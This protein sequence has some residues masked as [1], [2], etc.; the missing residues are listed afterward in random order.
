MT[1]KPFAPTEEQRAVIDHEGSAFV[2]ACPGAGKTRILIE[3]ARELFGALRQGQGIAF[4]SFTHA[5]V[6]ELETRLSQERLL[7]A[8]IFP[9]F[10]GTFDSFVW[11]FLVAPFGLPGATVRPRLIADTAGLPVEPY[12]NAQTLPLSCFCP[13]TGA[14]FP[15]EAKSKG[16]DVSKK[17]DYQVQAYETTASRIR[18]R[19]LARGHLGFDEARSVALQRISDTQIARRIAL[20]LKGRFCEVIVDEAQDCNPDDLRI[21]AWLRDSGLP[22]KVVCDPNQAIYEFRG[23]VTDHLSTFAETFPAAQ[24]KKVTGNFRSSPNICKAVAGFRPIPV[25]GD[26]DEALGS[27]RGHSASVEILSY[28]GISV[29]PSIGETFSTILRGAGILPSSAPIVASTKASGAAA[30]GQP[31]ATGSQDRTLRLAEV[32]SEF[33]FAAGYSDMK[34]AMDSAHE[35]F[36]LLEGK[37]GGLSYH[38]Y[39]AD[40]DIDP[41]SWRSQVVKLLRTLR[42]S[43]GVHGDAR[44]WHG[45]V[46]QVLER[47][48]SIDDGQTISQKLRWNTNLEGLLA[49][50]PTD[51]PLPRTIHSV[52]GMQFPAVCVV[53]TSRTL[54]RILDFLLT[55]EPADQAENARKLYVAASRAEKLLVLAVPRSQALRLKTHLEAQGASV[56]VREI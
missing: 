20:A 46:K 17:Q 32:V 41:A 2:D 8:P 52:K 7:P 3:R 45:A 21:I 27:L 6:F 42:F 54:G 11:H 53:M 50:A 37:L 19:L 29:P 55:G 36:L 22:T 25:R 31:K 5:A 26:P 39:I 13:D 44:G 9:N 47:E 14:I 38:Q 56:N 4:L 28:G 51:T 40:N 34:K 49:D 18:E 15:A 1:P 35:L 24:R 10:I 48:L 30:S 33:Q 23:G 43:L 12:E 16:F